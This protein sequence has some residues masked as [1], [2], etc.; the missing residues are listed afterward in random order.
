MEK[1]RKGV[2]ALNPLTILFL[3]VV[4]AVVSV[5]FDYRITLLTVLVMILIAVFS[6]VGA[7]YIKLWMKSMLL[8]CIICF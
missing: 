3:I 5:I 2:R 8:I 7:S 6:G 1:E 4:L